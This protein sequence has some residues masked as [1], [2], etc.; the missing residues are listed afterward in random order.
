MARLGETYLIAAEVLIRQGEYQQALEYINDLRAR[1]AYK[2]GEDRS[3]YCDGGAAY[4]EN[5]LGYVT[6]GNVNS[7]FPENSYYESNK[8]LSSFTRRR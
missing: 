2:E 3:A 5:S 7:Y 6:M 8:R 4:N 1:A